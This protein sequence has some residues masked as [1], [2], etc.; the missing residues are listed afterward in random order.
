MADHLPSRA[1]SAQQ[2]LLFGLPPSEQESKSHLKH[3]PW[4]R[5]LAC[6]RPTSTPSTSSTATSRPP[7]SCSR[8]TAPS[9]G[10][11]LPSCKCTCTQ[12]A[13]TAVAPAAL[14]SAVCCA[15]PG[16]LEPWDIPGAPNPILPPPASALH[17]AGAAPRPARAPPSYCGCDTPTPPCC[18]LFAAKI[19][20]FGLCS[21]LS[22][23]VTHV[24]NVLSGT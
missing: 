23:G 20:D 5:P 3:Q 8:A 11:W 9:P 7:T 1:C 4:V 24:S 10:A 15:Y 19:A 17:A 12:P 6:C 18:S 22:P 16:T 13:A 14:Q 2:V 21:A